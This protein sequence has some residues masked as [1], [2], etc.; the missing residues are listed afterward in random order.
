MGPD[1]NNIVPKTTEEEQDESFSIHNS[2]KMVLHKLDSRH[3]CFVEYRGSTNGPN[4]DQSSTIDALVVH[5]DPKDCS[6]IIKALSQALPLPTRLQHLKRVKKSSV[7]INVNDTQPTKRPKTE[8]SSPKRPPQ[9]QLLL[10]LAPLPTLLESLKVNDDGSGLN[11]SPAEY[12]LAIL[13]QREYDES[14]ST[15][16]EYRLKNTLF[17]NV[18]VPGRPPQS[19]TE[20]DQANQIWPTHFFP[21]QSLEYKQQQWT[22][23]S[24]ELQLMVDTVQKLATQKGVALVMDPISNQVIATSGDEAELQ[25]GASPCVSCGSLKNPLATPILFA[26]QGVSRLE[27]HGNSRHYLSSG[28]HLYCNYEPTVFESM[29]VVH[30]RFARVVWANLVPSPP[31]SVWQQGLSKHSIHC[32][33]GTNHHFRAFEYILQAHDAVVGEPQLFSGNGG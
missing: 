12:L 28:Y 25:E 10:G 24:Q 32:L 13:Q 5:V 31:R 6:R 1:G 9:L 4:C 22:L 17:Y 15:T 2:N 19:Q 11:S 23:P 16:A 30:S 33:P 14:S 21:L 7:M 29:A 3:A 26:I 8:N 27:R 18:S 20:A